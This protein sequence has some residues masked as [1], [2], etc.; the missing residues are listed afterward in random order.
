MN[1]PI[2]CEILLPELFNSRAVES[3]AAVLERHVKIRSTPS[4]VAAVVTRD[5]VAGRWAVG[6]HTYGE[7]AQTIRVSDLYDLASVTKVVATGM[8]Y[9]LLSEEGVVDL[10]TPVNEVIGEFLVDRRITPRVLLAHCGGLPAHVHLFKRM[11]SREEVIAAVCAMT[12]EYEPLSRSIYS[13]MGFILL[14]E[15][16]ERKTGRP[17]NELFRDY[18][19]EPLGLHETVF[20][21]GESALDRIVPTEDDTTWRGRLVHGEVHDENASVMR[22]VAPHAGLFATVDNVARFVQLWLNEGSFE[23]K[24][25]LAHDTIKK[26]RT[27]ASLVEGSTWALGWDT[28]TAQKSTSG[29]YFSPESYGILG[30]TGTS[31]WVDPER[32]IGVVLLTNRVHPT[33]ESWGIRELRPEFHDAV[34]EAM[35]I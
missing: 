23:G 2:S 31:I 4:A 21:P 33:R 26:F 27:R 9:A 30:F 19:R 32:G 28:V 29:K 11:I 6:R 17:L 18:V 34:G 20:C 8:L 16:L 1:I 22:G 14:G 15:I 10:D 3:I 7:E 24:R 5:G 35:K 13:D 25:F 12:L